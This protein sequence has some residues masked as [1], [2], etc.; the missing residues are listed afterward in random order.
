MYDIDDIEEVKI[1]F[2][3]RNMPLSQLCSLNLC[4]R[5]QMSYKYRTIVHGLVL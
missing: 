1:Q 5:I 4:R 3:M 2:H